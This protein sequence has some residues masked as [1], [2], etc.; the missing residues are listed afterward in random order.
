MS[1]SYPAARR[2]WRLC[3]ALGLLNEVQGHGLRLDRIVRQPQSHFLLLGGAGACKA[4]GSRFGRK[5]KK[6]ESKTNI[7][8]T[9]KDDTDK[10]LEPE[11]TNLRK[12]YDQITAFRPGLVVTEKGAS[13]LAQSFVDK[14][15]VTAVHRWRKSN[16]LRLA[17]D[18]GAPINNRT[19][20]ITKKGHWDRGWGLRG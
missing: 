6:G 17:R 18:Y 5:D 19:D 14:V 12:S 9:K 13:G 20:K 15:G 8:I 4:T 2:S 1:L 10:I 3:R 16:D 11:E 7:E